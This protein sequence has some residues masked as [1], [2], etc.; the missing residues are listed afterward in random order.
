M[1]LA[2][3]YTK[4]KELA[5]GNADLLKAIEEQ[6]SADIIA[7]TKET[8]E[9]KADAVSKAQDLLVK[10]SRGMF[11]ALEK[12]AEESSAAQKGFA[13]AD[14]LLSQAVA[15]ANAIEGASKAAKD[16]GPAAPFTLA[17]YIASMIGTVVGSFVSIKGILS[18]ADAPSPGVGGGT[19]TAT[20]PLIPTAVARTETAG[21]QNIQSFV[22]QSELQGAS[23]INDN[24][25]GQTSLNPG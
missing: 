14:V 11:A 8:E 2:D 6:Y 23:L 1:V 7:I 24:L 4:R 22:V 15:M 25:Y 3:E 9:Q 5:E 17:A 19:V 12:G 21:A 16:T 20:R 13:I 10:N 18:E